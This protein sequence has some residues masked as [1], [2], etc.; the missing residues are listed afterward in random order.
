MPVVPIDSVKVRPDAVSV[1]LVAEPVAAMAL[2][3]IAAAVTT[4]LE[5]VKPVNV[6]V[7]KVVAP[8]SI[9]NVAV[10]QPDTIASA[11]WFL[12]AVFN[13]GMLITP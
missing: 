8:S 7:T 12:A 13:D 1:T 3:A 4:P 6:C 5:L 9:V 10:D 11:M 2:L